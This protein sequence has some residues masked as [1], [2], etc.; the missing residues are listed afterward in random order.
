MTKPEDVVQYWFGAFGDGYPGDKPEM[1]WKKNAEVDADIKA[2]FGAAC[3]ASARGE[4][5]DW[6]TTA[7]GRQAHI[8]L[9]DQMARNMHRNSADMYAQDDLALRIALQSVAEGDPWGRPY[10]EL[11]FFLMPLM[12]A[13]DV[14][15]QRLSCRMFGRALSEAVD[16]DLT[17]A[18]GGVN[19]AQKHRV[20]VERFG[21]FPHRNALL[22]RESTA[23]EADFLKEP[24]S[25]F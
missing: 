16:A 24:G 21:R 1:W 22:G 5:A 19:Y 25:S 6:A 17:G 11:Q 23:E 14:G 2:R 15:I 4:L 12:H 9:I 13:E 7:L 20:I 10:R 8:L 18:A 3:D